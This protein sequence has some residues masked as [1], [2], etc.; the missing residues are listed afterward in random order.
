MQN[1]IIL[2]SLLFYIPTKADDLGFM[3]EKV[4]EAFY[5][6]ARIDHYL[7]ELQD[8]LIPK[9]YKYT[10]GNVSF[11]VTVFLQKRIEYKTTFP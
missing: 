6:Q 4:G 7:Q 8:R 3:Q 10:I 11:V 5:R 9:E 2:I 1:L